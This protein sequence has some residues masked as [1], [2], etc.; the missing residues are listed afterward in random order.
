MES[1]FDAVKNRS[2]DKKKFKTLTPPPIKFFL[3]KNFR[4]R[5]RRTQN[6]PWN[7]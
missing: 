5:F 3:S 4:L 6:K 7:N 2:S 1:A